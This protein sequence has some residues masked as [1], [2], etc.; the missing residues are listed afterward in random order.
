MVGMRMWARWNRE[1]AVLQAGW[2]WEDVLRA[3]F[4]VLMM[5]TN[6]EI[7]AELCKC[8]V[9]GFEVEAGWKGGVGV[10]GNLHDGL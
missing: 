10:G 7:G 2:W 4:K 3:G 8:C 1:A 5:N 9:C 6:S